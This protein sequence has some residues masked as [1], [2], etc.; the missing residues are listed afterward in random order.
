MADGATPPGII[1]S[2]GALAG[3]PTT[4]F[5][6]SS[7]RGPIGTS[8]AS[9]FALQAILGA[10]DA[11]TLSHVKA[12]ELG[13]LQWWPCQIVRVYLR[14]MLAAVAREYPCG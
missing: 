7:W 6:N 5:M 3:P 10:V 4:V 9:S 2:A 11:W 1:T 8:A 12:M 14:A 13:L